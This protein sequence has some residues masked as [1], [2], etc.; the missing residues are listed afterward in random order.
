MMMTVEHEFGAMLG[1]HRAH[2]RRIGEAAKIIRAEHRRMM[3]QNHTE[4]IFT[5][6]LRQHFGQARK[7]TAMQAPG[8]GERQRR[9]RGR[10]P[11]QR[12]RPA[13]PHERKAL[14]ASPRM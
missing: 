4:Q 10:K 3:D 6:E 5:P 2:R 7:L 1:Q 8:R 11:D 13:P 12:E 9:Q 14:P